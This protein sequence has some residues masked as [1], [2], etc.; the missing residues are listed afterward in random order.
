METINRKTR[1]QLNLNSTRTR[2]DIKMKLTPLNYGALH[3]KYTRIKKFCM[4]DL[5]QD[6]ASNLKPHLYFLLNNSFLSQQSQL[7]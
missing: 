7:N 4:F 5:E 6:V 2:L 3:I 1:N